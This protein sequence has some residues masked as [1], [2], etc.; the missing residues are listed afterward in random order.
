[1]NQSESIKNLAAALV[2][3][4]A[5]VP[6]IGRDAANP[7]FKSKY[8]SLGHIIS[9]ITP[10]LTECGLAVTC[11]PEGENHLRVS[12]LHTS[13]EYLSGSYKMRPVKDDPQALGSAI[14]YQRRYAIAAILNLNVDEDDD[15]NEA[16]KPVSPLSSKPTISGKRYD[17]MV[18][19]ISEGKFTKEDALKRFNLTKEQKAEINAL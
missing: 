16:S 13:G 9:K 7:F 12:L 14:T 4:Q 5:S 17:D 8:A 10:T 6:A 3:F 15:G 11:I 19:A 2:K 18:K 1:M